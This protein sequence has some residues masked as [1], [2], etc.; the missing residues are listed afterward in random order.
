MNL[1]LEAG[2]VDI[3]RYP[4]DTNTFVRSLKRL[5]RRLTAT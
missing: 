1:L 2:A 5:V 4:I 3:A